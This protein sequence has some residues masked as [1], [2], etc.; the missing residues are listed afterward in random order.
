MRRT[1]S[2]PPYTL[3]ARYYD[4]LAGDA[5]AMN[6]HARRKVLGEILTRARAVCDL[7]CGTGSTALELARSGK[8]VFAVDLSAAMCR[9]ARRKVRRAGLSVKVI[10][11]DMRRLRLPEPVDLVLSEF[12][13]LNHLPRRS[14]LAR[15]ACA[16]FRALRSGGWFYFDLNTLLTLRK[17]YATAL[18]WT[19]EPDFCLLLR[20][21]C[22]LRRQK[23][24]LDFDWFIPS[25][26]S[27]RRY[28]ERVVDTFWTDGEI[29]S[30]LRNAG[31]SR[32]R[33]WD[34]AAVR[35]PSF[36]RRRGFDSYY[37]AQKPNKQ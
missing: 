34:G 25:G 31:F 8:R 18:R 19:E 12:N 16:V 30:A 3:L 22:D 13:P 5:V 35:P 1:L 2:N 11:A 20:G 15:A 17:E 21:G 14:D 36:R 27:W 26:R 37:L 23:G 24:W 4:R 29:R 28:H 6:R 10:C 32:I 33:S 9:R 7:G